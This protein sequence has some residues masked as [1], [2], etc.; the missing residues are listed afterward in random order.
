MPIENMEEQGLEKNPKLEIS[1]WIFNLTLP[2]MKNDVNLKK[3]LMD[4]I[5]EDCKDLP[6]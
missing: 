1:Q 2:S 3:K 5:R 4:A 6:Q